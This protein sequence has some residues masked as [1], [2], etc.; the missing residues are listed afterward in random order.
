MIGVMRSKWGPAVIGGVIGV[1][2]LVFVFYGIFVPG[3]GSRGPGVAGEVNGE[4]ISYTE[5]SRALNQRIEFFKGLMGGKVSEA[6]LE[7]FRVGE[8][9]F[10][11]LAQRKVFGQIA[12]REGFYPSSQE[13]LDEILKQDVFQKDGRFDKT[14]YRNL[15]QANALTPVRYEEMVGRELMDRKF[16]EFL[17]SLVQIT[18]VE[19]DRELRIAREK[20]KFKYVYVDH[21]SVRKLLPKDL[22]PEEQSAKL[23]EKVAEI[24]KQVIPALSSGGAIKYP[25]KTSD[26]LTA[27]SNVIPGVGSVASIQ[28]D[29]FAL[30]K[31]AAAQR[32]ALPGGT[33]FALALS[34]EQFN[35]SSASAKDRQDARAKLLGEKQNDFFRRFTSAL[36]KEAKISRNEEVVSRGKGSS[37]PVSFDQ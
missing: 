20:R 22:K 21:E 17:V 29:L 35:P 11:D 9:V 3:S 33:F 23:D 24:E 8:S 2:T 10:N 13:I 27:R 28:N 6:Q 4:T 30:K 34:S 18:P 32:F 25:V 16:R 12:K 19:V 37:V 1:I 5:F 26:W 36:M 15:L 7:Q 31:G 14:L